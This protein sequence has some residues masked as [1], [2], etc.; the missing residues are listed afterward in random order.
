[1]DQHTIT[2]EL[3]SAGTNLAL[4]RLP[5]GMM[6]VTRDNLTLVL[7]FV[8]ETTIQDSPQ[9]NQTKRHVSGAVS[10]Y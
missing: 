4:E 10:T 7:S 9:S 2:C 6:F 3:G 5:G 1:M 8:F